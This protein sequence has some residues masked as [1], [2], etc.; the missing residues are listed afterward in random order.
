MNTK[1]SK[2]CLRTR[3]FCNGH[4]LLRLDKMKEMLWEQK[5]GASRQLRLEVN[6][7][8]P[9]QTGDEAKGCDPSAGRTNDLLFKGMG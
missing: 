5:F 8:L 2:H 9:V 4:V 6:A 1:K 7:I 3:R